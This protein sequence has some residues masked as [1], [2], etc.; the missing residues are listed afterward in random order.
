LVDLNNAK[1]VLQIPLQLISDFDNYMAPSAISPDGNRFAVVAPETARPYR[2]MKHLDGS[3]Y[4]LT[5]TIIYSGMQLVSTDTGSKLVN[6]T[7]DH[8]Y[9]TAVSFSEDSSRLAVGRSNGVVSIFD[10]A[11]GS[12]LGELHGPRS[13]TTPGRRSRQT[14]K[15]NSVTQL[16]FE[17]IGEIL[18]VWFAS[19]D[20]IIQA[21]NIKPSIVSTPVISIP[22]ASFSVC[23]GTNRVIVSSAGRTRLVKLDAG[24][25]TRDFEK[26]LSSS[27]SSQTLDGTKFTCS[28]DGK[29]VA[30]VHDNMIRVWDTQTGVL[31]K[32][33]QFE[34][35]SY[36]RELNFLHTKELKLVVY[37]GES[38]L[39]Y[40]GKVYVWS[41]TT[42]GLIKTIW[43]DTRA[44]PAA[45]ECGRGVCP[46]EREGG[47]PSGNDIEVAEVGPDRKTM[48]IATQYGARFALKDGVIK[49]TLPVPWSNGADA[50][51]FTQDS[52]KV[53]WADGLFDTDS[54]NKIEQIPQKAYVAAISPSGGRLAVV[55]NDPNKDLRTSMFVISIIENGKI[56]RTLSQM[57]WVSS[58]TFL[59][60]E[61]RIASGGVDKRVRI[62]DLSSAAGEPISLDH[63]GDLTRVA[64]ACDRLFSSDDSVY[65]V[66][67]QTGVRRRIG[68]GVKPA[69]SPD[70]SKIGTIDGSSI[71]IWDL[72]TA[73][74]LSRFVVHDEKEIVYVAFLDEE[75]VVSLGEDGFVKI[76]SIDRKKWGG[77]AADVLKSRVSR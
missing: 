13:Q 74:E 33:R 51:A 3:S 49:A 15:Q 22:G 46:P 60:D 29:W 20:G 64:W 59:N 68:A 6:L 4:S 43:G 63:D 19:E 45:R 47:A 31:V 58:L 23:P 41:L 7:S 50:V 39:A 52:K 55:F 53:L 57:G 54:G 28:P 44:L 38:E 69:I 11:D 76:Y 18:R 42:T 36:V 10:T 65:E 62:W 66:D 24:G 9:I 16:A 8:A 34:G 32:E 56:I 61:N 25:V 30:G 72:K 48:I 70:C 17:K 75:T 77:A 5:N 73:T 27:F 37:G 40:E 12:L 26:E 2:V 35:I 1:I 14:N 21:W 71:I 67:I